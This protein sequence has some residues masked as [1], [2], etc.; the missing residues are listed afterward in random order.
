MKTE[1]A[2]AG[3]P[4]SSTAVVLNEDSRRFED[5][6]CA[7]AANPCMA[8]AQEVALSEPVLVK[9]ETKP[10]VKPGQRAGGK[11][12][13]AI[14]EVYIAV[15]VWCFFSFNLELHDQELTKARGLYIY[16]SLYLYGS[17]FKRCLVFNRAK[18]RHGDSVGSK[19]IANRPGRQSDGNRCVLGMKL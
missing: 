11:L 19:L 9:I 5:A 17:G 14:S 4:V 13:P 7:N 10:S 16:I 12:K 2:D 3:W 18:R 1:E 6:K 15:R 8:A